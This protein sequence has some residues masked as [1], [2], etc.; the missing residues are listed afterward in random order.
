MGNEKV[1]GNVYVKPEESPEDYAPYKIPSG[2]SF[3]VSKLSNLSILVKSLCL[4]LWSEFSLVSI[5]FKCFS[6]PLVAFNLINITLW[7]SNA[8]YPTG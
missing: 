7:L 3:L 8:G 1:Q 4:F 6:S 5:H 2:F